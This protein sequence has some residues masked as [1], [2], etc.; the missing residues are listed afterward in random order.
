MGDCMNRMV[1]TKILKIEKFTKRRK[2]VEKQ[3]NQRVG[4]GGN[5][6]QVRVCEFGWQ[7][8]LVDFES[9]SL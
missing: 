1:L 2:S 5:A 8:G 9:F 3:Q 7:N 4:N 6:H